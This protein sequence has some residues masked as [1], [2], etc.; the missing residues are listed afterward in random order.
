GRRGTIFAGIGDQNPQSLLA[1]YNPGQYIP[2]NMDPIKNKDDNYA[3][4]V[5]FNVV[6]QFSWVFTPAASTVSNVYD[7]ILQY[8]EA[9]ISNLTPDQKKKLQEAEQTLEADSEKYSEYELKYYEALDAY[10]A[11]Y[12]TAANGGA[13]IPRSIKLKLASALRSWEGL[14]H[15]SAVESAIAVISIYEALE[16]ENF[17]FQLRERY[18]K[19]TLEADL[20]SEFQVVGF[21]PPYRN[22]FGDA[23]WTDFTF[24]Q[25]DMDNQRNSESLGV[26]GNL[27]GSFG[28][29]RISGDGSF[30]QD[31]KFVKIDQTDLSF[32]C[33]LMRVSFDRSW[34]NPLVLS[35]RA[36]RW[37]K[38]TPTYGSKLSTG[39]D[40]FGDVAPTG[41]MTVIPTAAILSKD[42]VINGKFNQTQVEEFNRAIAANASVGIGPFS[43][44][45]RFNMENN[46]GSEKGTIAVNGIT[47]KDVQVIALICQLL[48]ESPDPDASLV[49]PS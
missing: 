31:S 26:S 37:A 34:M 38:G 18:N 2:P 19:G 9:P 27:D 21:S 3:L 6:P 8:K 20:G 29:F 42:L 43:I 28:I 46:T 7:S 45:G 24:T 1:I 12:A 30:E 44:S 5:L 16:P 14:G 13:P 17:W 39:G 41:D 36:W 40:I 33:K 11:A 48:P 15:K 4:S 35:S 49:W 22:W 32:S 47:A 10:D 23:G 25:T